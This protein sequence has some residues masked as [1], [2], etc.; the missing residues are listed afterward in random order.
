[1]QQRQAGGEAGPPAGPLHLARQLG[2]PAP[3]SALSWHPPA[4]QPSA[5]QAASQVAVCE[6]AQQTH[7]QKVPGGCT[8]SS[9]MLHRSLHLCQWPHRK[10]GILY[11]ACTRY[12]RASYGQ[13]CLV[14]DQSRKPRALASVVRRYHLTS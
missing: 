6:C 1:M 9:R 4:R 3:Q 8:L 7:A 11:A 2:E 13:M 14:V 10:P 12:S 5:L